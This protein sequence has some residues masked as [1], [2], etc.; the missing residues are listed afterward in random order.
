MIRRGI[1]YEDVAQA[2]DELRS[3]GEIPT[4]ERIRNLLGGTGSNTTISKYLNEWR[5]YAIGANVSSPSDPVQTAVQRV[6]QQLR[7]ETDVEINKIREE[8]H[9]LITEAQTKEK[10]AVQKIEEMQSELAILKDQSHQLQGSKEILLL[11]YKKLQE[12]HVLLQER[13][14]GLDERYTDFQ[15]ITVQHQDD[16]SQAHKKEINHVLEKSQIQNDANQKLISELKN[17]NEIQRQNFIV[18]V[19]SLKTKNQQLNK[20]LDDAKAKIKEKE[21]ELVKIKTE[22]TAITKERDQLAEQIIPQKNYWSFLEKNNE[23]TNFILSE[24]KEIPKIDLTLST[25]SYFSEASD[26]FQEFFKTSRETKSIL[27]DFNKKIGI[28]DADNK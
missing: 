9:Q 27:D 25:L 14:K 2:A 18:E 16:L 17:Y 15:R 13:Y 19:D 23:M 26:K 12:E 5:H 11:D 8:S 22:L 1:S 4:I 20:D 24:V 10:L 21:I 28:L 6:W 7:E 3:Q